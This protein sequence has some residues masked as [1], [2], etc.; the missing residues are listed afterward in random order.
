MGPVGGR[1]VVEGTDCGFRPIPSHANFVLA[2]V[3]NEAGV[4]CHLRDC[5][6]MVCP[7][8]GLGMPGLV[9]IGVPDDKGLLHLADALATFRSPG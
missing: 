1:I 4:V 5:G 6:V 3:E 7:G 2:A 9:R 8:S